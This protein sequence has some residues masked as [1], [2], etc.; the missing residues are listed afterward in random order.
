MGTSRARWLRRLNG[1]TGVEYALVLFLI[2]F[3]ATGAVIATGTNVEQVLCTAAHAVAGDGACNPA[4]PPE[5]PGEPELPVSLQGYGYRLD[6]AADTA[7]CTRVGSGGAP[8]GPDAVDAA[9]C[10][11]SQS[12]AG[13]DLATAAGLLADIAGLSQE[14]A[15][16]QCGA[17]SS[18]YGWSPDCTDAS[19]GFECRGLVRDRPG[20]TFAAAPS[21]CSGFSPEGGDGALLE[22]VGLIADSA[23]DG[24]DASWCEIEVP[25]IV[26][27]G[28]EVSC[29]SPTMDPPSA[30][31][32]RVTA[33]GDARS[34]ESASPSD[35]A[36][37]PD[38]EG[39]ALLQAAALIP[40]G[41]GVTPESA[42][43]SCESRTPAFFWQYSCTDPGQADLSCLS[44]DTVTMSPGAGSAE[45]CAAYAPQPGDSALLDMF[46]SMVPDDQQGLMSHAQYLDF[47]AAETCSGP[48][49]YGY[50]VNC[51]YN[52]ATC[53]EAQPNG[54]GGYNLAWTSS[55]HCSVTPDPA[56]VSAIEAAGL[57]PGSPSG[58]SGALQASCPAT[59]VAHGWDVDCGAG[60]ATC[61]RFE[62]ANGSNSTSAA[63]PED[64]AV[65]P[66]EMQ[67]SY[68]AAQ[69]WQP[70][71]PDVT[72]ES[73]LAQCT[74]VSGYAY[75]TGCYS[76]GADTCFHVVQ[77]LFGARGTTAPLE[78]CQVDQDQAVLDFLAEYEFSYQPGRADFTPEMALESQNCAPPA[79]MA[80]GYSVNCQYG[81]ADC[82][83]VEEGST[84]SAMAD[85]YDRCLDTQD[86]EQLSWLAAAGLVPGGRTDA[87]AMEMCDSPNNAYAW[88]F[89][90]D[91]GPGGPIGP[92][93]MQVQQFGGNSVDMQCIAVNRDTNALM[94]ADD[95]ACNSYTS[96]AGDAA[97]FA[98]FAEQMSGMMDGNIA[99][100]EQASMIDPG[101]CTVETGEDDDGDGFSNDPSLY[102]V[103]PDEDEWGWPV[104]FRWQVG[105]WQG[106]STCGEPS[107]LTRE[108]RCFGTYQND[109][110]YDAEA[111]ISACRGWGLPIPPNRY[112]GLGAACDYD[113]ARLDDGDWSSTC[114]EYAYR[115]PTYSCTDSTGSEVDLD[116]CVE[117]PRAGAFRVDA[118]AVETGEN[119]SG[120]TYSWE[121]YTQEAGCFAQNDPGGTNGPTLF[122]ETSASCIRS[123]DTW[124][125]DESLCQAAK[126][127]TGYEATGECYENFTT[128]GG[129]YRYDGICLGHR[130]GQS[131]SY[132]EMAEQWRTVVFP[133]YINQGGAAACLD[134]GAVCCQQRYNVQTNQTETVGSIMPMKRYFE[135][136]VTYEGDTDR[137]LDDGAGPNV[138]YGTT[139]Y[140]SDGVF[141]DHSHAVR[142]LGDNGSG[143]CHLEPGT[144]VVSCGAID[145]GCRTELVDQDWPPELEQCDPSTAYWKYDN[146]WF[147]T[148]GASSKTWTPYP[149]YR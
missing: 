58:Q 20:V 85:G 136:Y 65:A 126:P 44:F 21:A 45:Q 78:A 139:T 112:E 31:C 55:S 68:I 82:M 95:S 117:N 63:T 135:L 47:D 36:T 52:Y 5:E 124:M 14:Q 59:I 87:Q 130:P 111:P 18:V 93:P 122:S 90:C 54:S 42:A 4:D 127:W 146:A 86:S 107:S 110:E 113:L 48:R 91:G 94:F 116:L 61:Q 19:I 119:L 39:L 57:I 53:Y 104:E 138:G 115:E 35:C 11:A 144:V 134:S 37:A 103:Q 125:E 8:A 83:Q 38:A 105:A 148:S 30:S 121:T 75:G 40:G 15:L 98:P 67:A 114:S 60:T 51:P 10:A 99:L 16:E 56:T 9:Q 3:T 1:A 33:Q 46:G 66:D 132:A 96:Q 49:V 76:G 80:Y 71:G 6:C 69:L 100:V 7:T 142:I 32:V 41:P 109:G 29:V 101:S 17:S 25:E 143:Y 92:G 70:G 28:Y 24:Y 73:L 34:V 2:A 129:N 72:A 26:A 50:Q 62:R 12:S 43:E 88:Y 74:G 145:F 140:T 108:I 133:G 23:R 102:P 97:L 84:F 89:T 118:P 128:S 149:P 22:G 81:W 120:C 64:C 79:R 141:P 27:Y 77:E 147:Y 106:S 137:Y 131:S 123:D 13:R